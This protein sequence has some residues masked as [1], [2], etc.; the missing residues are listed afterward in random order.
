M[1]RRTRSV[2]T[3]ALVPKVSCSTFIIVSAWMKTNVNR[4]LL[5][6]RPT[7]KIRWEV[8]DVPVLMDTN[9]TEFCSF[10]FK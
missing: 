7:V 3:D 4:I 8:T 2:A 10:A 6:V 1:I 9:L 5:A